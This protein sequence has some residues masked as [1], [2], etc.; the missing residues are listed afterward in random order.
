MKG[1]GI[2]VGF[3]IVLILVAI[4]AYLG[5]K[6]LGRWMTATESAEGGA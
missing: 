6:N 3:V 4:V 1:K 2:V 5:G